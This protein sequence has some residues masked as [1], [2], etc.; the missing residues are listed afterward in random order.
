MII[1]LFMLWFTMTEGLL[2][3]HPKISHTLII[4]IILDDEAGL[5]REY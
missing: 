5:D 3:A 1:Y 2:P 4:K